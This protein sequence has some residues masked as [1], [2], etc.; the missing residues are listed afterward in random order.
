MPFSPKV[1]SPQQVDPH[2][3]LSPVQLMAWDPPDVS[4]A[5]KIS[6]FLQ[7][8]LAEPLPERNEFT[9]WKL[10]ENEARSGFASVML[11]V[12][13]DAIVS[14]CTITPKRFWRNG[15]EHFFGEIG[16]TFTD[17]QY[18]RKGMFG[19]LVNAC[20]SRAKAA[21]IKAIYGLPN[22]QSLP[23]YVKK[24]NFKIK[25]D[26]IL[27][28]Y[29]MPIGV[30]A[31]G[32]RS[33]I[34]RFPLLRS[35]LCS[36]FVVTFSRKITW[37]FTSILLSQPKEISFDQVKVF[38][39]EFDLLWK[40]CRSALEN[41]Q[42]RD[43]RYLAWRYEKNP[44][45]VRIFAAR[46]QNELVGYV[47]LLTLGKDDKSR[48]EFRHT[49]LL[50]WLYEPK[51]KVEAKT[52]LL[53]MAIRF[54]YEDGA[55]VLSV[56]SSRITSLPLPFKRGGFFKRNIEMPVIFYSDEEGSNILEDPAGW[57]FTWSDTDSF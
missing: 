39:S 3:P 1:D 18:L 44:F 22:D 57:H 25:K 52:A 15:K 50:D 2:E 6:Q 30:K 32:L 4:W 40:R 46:H 8:Q 48:D 24:L 51:A 56:I 43:S 12:P 11:T 42:V 54:S 23:G 5:N 55:D 31:I 41:S 34:S 49:I 35:L 45:P 33:R 29:V 9:R 36:S 20:R 26:L 17:S 19:T 16:D 27:D 38:G 10:C 13:G 21:G 53:Y 7:S 37:L 14:T 28:S 47:A